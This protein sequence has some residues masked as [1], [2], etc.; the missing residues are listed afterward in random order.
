MTNAFTW[1]ELTETDWIFEGIN[2]FVFQILKP[3]F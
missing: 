2:A 3:S 1:L